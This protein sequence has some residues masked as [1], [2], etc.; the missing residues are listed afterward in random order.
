MSIRYVGFAMLL[1]LGFL[2]FESVKAQEMTAQQWQEDLKYLQKVVTTE[3]ANLFHTITREAWEQQANELYQQIPQ[4]ERHQVVAGLSRLVAAFRIGHTQLSV[5][6]WRRHGNPNIG[7]RRFPVLTYVFSDGVYIR[8][9]REKYRDIVGARVVSIG[10]KPIKEAMEA[11]RPLVPWEN[12]QFFI[13]EIPYFLSCPEVLHAQ[14]VIDNLQ[15]TTLLIE[16]NGK[17]RT[18]KLEAEASGFFPGDYGMVYGEPGWV[19][20]RD[21]S[22][23]PTPLYLKNLE[24]NFYFEYLPEHKLVYVRHS[25]VRD[26]ADETIARFFQRVM[27]FVDENDVEKLVL[28]V[29]LNSGGNNYLNK[30]IIV[31]LIANRKVNQPGHL[32]TIIGRRTFSAAQNLVNELEKY[33]ETVFV[34]EPTSENVNFWG[35]VR[36]YNLPNS[37]LPVRLSWM[38]WQDG[39]PRDDRPWL[40]PEIAVDLSFEDYKNN[41][42]PV[43]AEILNYGN[44]DP[45][46]DRIREY[47]ISGQNEAGRKAAMAYAADPRR[48]Y[49]D[50]EDDINRLG[51]NLLNEKKNTAAIAVFRLNTELYPHSANT[52]D[53]LA[54]SL[55]K[56]GDLNAAIETYQKA[57]KMDPNGVGQNSARMI[58]EIRRQM[59]HSR[60]SESH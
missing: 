39:D 31:G 20:V 54:E 46:Y 27:N 34:G 33:T 58:E 57:I 3:R 50:V 37:G 9:A 7:F 47:Y 53:S 38:W 59:D 18:V 43:M 1:L 15:E 24:R 26:E 14:G 19:D 17:Q 55:W 49:H 6:P 11:V 16:Q 45:L 29:R 42:D 28:D 13:S 21:F 60:R 56:T 10:K 51:Y 41:H 25:Q 4:L 5:I 44:Q 40:A 2:C 8:S 52:F 35:D 48:R 22:D 32:F 30:P 36:E 23:A 12:E